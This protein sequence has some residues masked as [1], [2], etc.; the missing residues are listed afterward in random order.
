MKS[1]YTEAAFTRDVLHLAK[2]R[3]WRRAHFRPGMDRRGKW[4]TAVQGDGAGFPDLVLI[5]VWPAVP[6]MLV[7]ELKVGRNKKTTA[8]SEWLIAFANAGV[9]A[10][11]WYPSDWD[12]IE[13]TLLDGP[14]VLN[15]V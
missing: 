7:A 12:E 11:T 3:G 10:Y 1:T 13:K 14:D 2:L 15:R 5:R 9:A 8:Q 6:A 4:K